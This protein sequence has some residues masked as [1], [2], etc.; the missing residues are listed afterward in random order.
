MTNYNVYLSSTFRVLE[1]HR[2]AVLELFQHISDHFQ[3][4]AMEG[5]TAEDQSALEKC[6]GDVEKC[7]LY[8]LFLANRYGHIH[9]NHAGGLWSQIHGTAK[10]R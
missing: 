10:N 8:I 7:D 1:E 9:L 5:Y 4:T 2:K 6:I 3:V